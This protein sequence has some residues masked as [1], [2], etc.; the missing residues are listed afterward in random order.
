MLV[1]RD[2]FSKGYIWTKDSYGLYDY[3]CKD[4]VRISH[5]SDKT[6]ILRREG[7]RLEKEDTETSKFY[8]EDELVAD[9]NLFNGLFYIK[10]RGEFIPFIKLF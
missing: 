1:L 5:V 3:N 6:I 2:I 4:S 7:D 10:P 9:F 8:P